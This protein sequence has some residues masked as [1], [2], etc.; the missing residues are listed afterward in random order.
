MQCCGECHPSR[1]TQLTQAVVAAL[2]LHEMLERFGSLAPKGRCRGRALEQPVL[3]S[4]I[5]GREQPHLQCFSPAPRKEKE[6]LWIAWPAAR[7]AWG[8]PAAWLSAVLVASGAPSP[9]WKGDNALLPAQSCCLCHSRALGTARSSHA[10]L[11]WPCRP[12]A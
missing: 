8:Q 12:Q 3:E 4:S 7:V 1:H 11:C 5:T 6:K 9:P 10:P 2:L